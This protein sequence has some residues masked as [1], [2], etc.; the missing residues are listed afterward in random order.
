MK[1]RTAILFVKDLPAMTRFYRDGLGLTAIK[2]RATETWVPLDAGGTELALHAI[3]EDLA[4]DIQISTP[5]TP[6]EDTPIKLVFEVANLDEART[7][8]A[9]NGASMQESR[10]GSCDGC[11][12]EGNVFRITNTIQS[13]TVRP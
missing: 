12:P 1:L 10:W 13:S 7:H 9:A 4:R 5:P 11:D 3:P 6:R 2:S 8:L